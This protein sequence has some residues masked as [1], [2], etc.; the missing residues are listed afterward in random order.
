MLFLKI[1]FV[2]NGQDLNCL[3]SSLT[4]I[5]LDP[6]FRTKYGFQSLIQ[7][8]WV[9]LGHPFANRLGH[10]LSK[11]IEP[12]PVFLLFLDCVWQLLQQFPSAFQIS[13][14]YLTT[15]WDSV[16]VS[17]FDTFLFNCH[18]QRFMAERVSEVI[19]I[20]NYLFISTV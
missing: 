5:L 2:G 3:V 15:L 16:H 1:I 20:F 9:S 10:I 8:D 7:K 12:A 13:E 18:H 17:I 14:A 4:Q 11:D 19:V 6:F